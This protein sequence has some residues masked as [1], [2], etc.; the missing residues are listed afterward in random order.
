MLQQ[1]GKGGA[2]QQQE[3]YRYISY[4]LLS[5]TTEPLHA[6]KTC[7]LRV[8]VAPPAR[9]PQPA[10]EIFDML[11]D[12]M[13]L[14]AGRLAYF[15]TTKRARSFFDSLAGACPVAI[16]PAGFVYWPNTYIFLVCMFSSYAY[17]T[18]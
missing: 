14:E 17:H 18:C 5:S 6:P 2:S 10:G 4:P 1:L 8:V 9:R 16:N 15:G 11:E 12:L 13:L 3:W 7:T